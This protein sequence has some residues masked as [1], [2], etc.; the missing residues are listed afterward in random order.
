MI[1]D[2]W[3]INKNYPEFFFPEIRPFINKDKINEISKK[4]FQKNLKKRKKLE[5]MTILFVK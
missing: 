5:K 1:D 3:F 4:K 2:D